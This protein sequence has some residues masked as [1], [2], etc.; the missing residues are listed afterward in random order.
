MADIRV[1]IVDDSL[2][3]REMLTDI[4]EADTGI[5][6]VGTAENGLRAVELTCSLM[7]DV[8]AMDVT[9]PVMGGLEA[10]ERIMS[11]TPVPILVITDLDHSKIAFSALSKGALDVY[12]KSFASKEMAS[13]LIAKIKLLSKMKVIRHI[14]PRGNDARAGVPSFEQRKKALAQSG[15]I[16]EKKPVVPLSGGGE[17][18]TGLRSLQVVAIASSTGG[19]RAL[20]QIFSEMQEG[21]SVP[22]VVAQ[23]MNDGFVNGLVEWL[24]SVS[25]IK[26]KFG[27][28][29]E[30]LRENHAYF[31]PPGTHITV[32]ASG[33]V[34]LV[35]STAD[36][37]FHPSCNMLLSSVAKAFGAHSA[38][39][40]LTGMGDDGVEGIRSIREQG[41]Y[42]IAQDEAT[43][44]V[45]GMPKVAIDKGVVDKVSPL[46]EI[47]ATLQQ[48]VERKVR[49]EK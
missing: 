43:S 39:V 21:F 34:K 14:L 22:I 2:M 48:L 16:E 44:I 3:V 45:F 19:P 9:M 36:D 11:T 8:V 47:G 46:G 49:C 24:N 42:T 13:D 12:Q 7:P 37:L 29:G 17:R 35:S 26:V 38:G 23:H 6:V 20:A 28:N 30:M 4:L 18:K 15:G 32:N 10:I 31:A 25:P 27:A 33:Q 5:S 40:I 1:L 41:G